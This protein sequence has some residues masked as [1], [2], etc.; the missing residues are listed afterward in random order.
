MGM[1]AVQAA[2]YP[3]AQINLTGGGTLINTAT[4]LYIAA[5]FGLSLVV[6]AWLFFRISGSLFNPAITFA[7]TITGVMSPVRAIIVGVAQ[8]AGGIT[9][10]ALADGLTPGPLHAGNRLGGGTSIPQG[11]AQSEAAVDCR[12]VS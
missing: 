10:A 5:T 9:A 1:L 11:L 7:L 8:I 3:D 12:A 4:L 6:N 2:T